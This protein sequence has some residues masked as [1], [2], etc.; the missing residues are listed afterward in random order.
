[1]TTVTPSVWFSRTMRFRMA[2]VPSGSRPLN[3]SS[4]SSRSGEPTS[5]SARPSRCFMPSE[6]PFAF[7]L[8]TPSR[9]T[10]ASASRQRAGA[11]TTP[12]ARAFAMRFS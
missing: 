11:S 3:G 9:P 8:P 12:K 10:S 5:A 1:M 4:S 6:K 7:F 2:R